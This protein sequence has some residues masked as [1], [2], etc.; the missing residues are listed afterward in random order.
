MR[1]FTD[2][3]GRGWEASVAE[4]PGHDYKGRFFLRMVPER[5][6]QGAREVTLKDIRWN[7]LQT[8]RRTLDTMSDLELRRR[9]KQ[10]LGRAPGS[11]RAAE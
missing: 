3:T 6:E 9:L 1:A 10:A 5:D 7:S 2:D 11:A 8:A 4:R